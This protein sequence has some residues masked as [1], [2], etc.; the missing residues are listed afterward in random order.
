MILFSYI[1]GDIVMTKKEE[2]IKNEIQKIVDKV[3][4]RKIKTNVFLSPRQLDIISQLNEFSTHQ[5][6]YDD[7]VERDPRKI[8]YKTNQELKTALCALCLS[9][10]LINHRSKNKYT[11]EFFE[12]NI[13]VESENNDTLNIRFEN[14]EEKIVDDAINPELIF[15]WMIYRDDEGRGIFALI[16]EKVCDIDDLK[17][18]NTGGDAV[19]EFARFQRK[20]HTYKKTKETKSKES[21]Q[22]AFRNAVAQ[23]VASQIT[24]QQLLSGKDPMEFVNMLFGKPDFENSINQITS[25]FTQNKPLQI[26]HKKKNKKHN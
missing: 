11:K 16:N 18:Y 4:G 26:T 12:D 23:Q 24:A 8:P 17:D 13:F 10:A 3:A 19:Y 6:L 15:D 7:E 21:A 5:I 14:V 9:I 22:E 2:F 1:F 25:S 20:Y